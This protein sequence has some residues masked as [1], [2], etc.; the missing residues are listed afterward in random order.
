MRHK[1]RQ[2][3]SLVSLRLSA[4]EEIEKVFAG[5]PDIINLAPSAAAAN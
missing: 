5:G 2:A 3:P 1:H 4:G